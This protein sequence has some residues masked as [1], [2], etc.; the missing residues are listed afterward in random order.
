MNRSSIACALCLCLMI[1][2]GC[3]GVREVPGPTR[4]VE[5]PKIVPL[6]AECAALQ[7]VELPSGATAQTVIEAQHAALLRYEAQLNACST[8]GR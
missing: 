6:P 1:T 5:I 8:A 4:I 7:R 3:S 2:S